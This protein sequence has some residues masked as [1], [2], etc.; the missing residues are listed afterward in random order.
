MRLYLLRHGETPWNKAGRFQGQ[1]DIQ[2]NDSGRKLAVMTREGMGD[3]HF[4]KVFCSPLSRAV[5]TAHL[6]LEGRYPLD[7]IQTDERIKEISFGANEGSSIIEAKENP[8]HPMH[9]LLWHPEEYQ[10]KDGKGE[11]IAMVAER[12]GDFVRKEILPLEGQCENVLIVAHGALNRAILVAL[13]LKQIPDFW[14][15]KYLNCC[16]TTLE[17]KQ[18]QMS[19]VSEAEI[20][21]DPKDYPSVWSKQ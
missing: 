8:A 1:T 2:L 9:V 5:E 7:Q 6:L 14:T 4:D 15:V 13:G 17:I 20:F 3:I 18:G 12:A 21:Y 10:P 16:V 11:S 19:I